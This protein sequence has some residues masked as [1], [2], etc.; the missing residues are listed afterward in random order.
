MGPARAGVPDA[1][2]VA[3]TA[4]DATQRAVARMRRR[5]G[6]GDAG[7]ADPAAV[8]ANTSGRRLLGGVPVAERLE[9]TRMQTHAARDRE[10][11]SV[12]PLPDA[13][14]GARAAA[15]PAPRPPGFISGL[16]LGFV[17]G[18]RCGRRARR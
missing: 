18:R 4:A 12:V 14:E 10:V 8:A 16:L 7:G 1:T 9:W 11:R 3:A 5:A 17:V 2:P 13:A 15:P 6:A